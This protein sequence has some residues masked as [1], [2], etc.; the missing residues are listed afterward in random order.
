LV[1]QLHER[2]IEAVWFAP[3][4]LGPGDHLDRK[5]RKAIDQATYFLVAVNQQSRNSEWVAK[6]T[7][8]ALQREQRGH[9]L[10]L[11]PLYLT[12]RAVPESLREYVAIDMLEHNYKTGFEDLVDILMGNLPRGRTSLSKFEGFVDSLPIVDDEL[13]AAIESVRS[14]HFGLFRGK[15]QPDWEAKSSQ[16]LRQ[17]L[18]QTEDL[19][20][21]KGISPLDRERIMGV[22][23]RGWG[24]PPCVLES[25][26]KD[27]HTWLRSGTRETLAVASRY[28]YCRFIN[29]PGSRR[30]R[31]S[32][33]ARQIEG[34]VTRGEIHQDEAPETDWLIRQLIDQKLIRPFARSDYSYEPDDE[35]E[36]FHEGALLES[37]GKAAYLFEINDPGRP[38][39]NY[40]IGR[41]PGSTPKGASP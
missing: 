3:Q 10:N 21:K 35:D 36:E 23:S 6:E 31:K 7:E 39:E 34:W 2:G 12:S 29:W 30:I 40:P 26:L 17:K 16:S 4:Q 15:G 32:D 19:L 24:T 13:E 14:E 33:L 41:F 27:I 22:L 5:I 11:I 25:E 8:Y 37:V 1:A 28:Y 9:D 20:S 18:E 38:D